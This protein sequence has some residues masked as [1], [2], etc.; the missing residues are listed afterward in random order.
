MSQFAFLQAEFPDI[1]G[2]AARA[3]TL[4]R[5][6]PRGAAFYCRLALETAVGW[7]YR[8][9]GTLKNPYDPTLAALLAEPSFQALVGR[10]LAVKARFVKDTGNAAAHGKPVSSGQAAGSLRE[11]FH[12]AYWL[13]RTYAKGPKPAPDAA[14]SIESLPKITQVAATTLAQLQEVARRF[15]ENVE[16]RQA[17]EEARRL[18]EEGRAA[19]EAEIKALQAEIAAAKAANQKVADTH[20]YREAETRDLFIDLL[21]REA[22]F[23]PKARDAIEVEVAGMPNAPGVGYVDYVLRG[24]DGKP[25]ALVEAKR[26]RKDPRIG[27]QQAKLY[28]D[29]LDKQYGQR[30]I[31]F[32]SNGYDHWIWDDTRHPP[33]P[34][35]GFLKKDELALMIQRRETRK[36][37]APEDIDRAIVERPYQHRAIRRI[38]EAFERD[39]QRKALLVMATGAGKTRTVIALVDLLLRANW[40]KRVLFLADR[41]ALVKQAA[42][43]FAKHLPGAATVNLLENRNQEGR[44]Y[45]STYPTMMGLIDEVGAEERRFGVGH[46][47]LVVIDEAH[48]SVYRKYKAIFEYFDS[49]LVGLTA[50]PKDE[51]DRD[52][53]RLFDL[54]TGVPTDAYGLDEA[55]KDCYLVPPRAVSLTTDFLDRGIRYDDLS[56]DE[57]EAWDALE[58]DDSGAVPAVVDAPA[59]NKWLFNAD[60]VDRVLQHLMA[61]G[62]KVEDGDRIGKT[63]IFAKSHD[64]A[65]FIQSRFDANYPYLAGHH[66][67]VIDFQTTYAQ[68]LIDDFSNPTKAPHI[69]I[70]VDMLDTGIDIP[71]VVNLVFFKPVRSKTKFWQM[72][73]RGT[74]LC[75]DLF[76]PGRHKEFF[77]IFDWCR[78][79]EFFN[80]NPN[81]VDGAGADSLAKRLFAARVEL[82]GEVDGRGSGDAPAGHY[83]QEATPLGHLGEAGSSADRVAEIKSLRNDLVAG[84]RTEISGMSLDNFLVRP[85]RRYVEKYSSGDA[86]KK[87]DADARHE[88]IDHVAGLPSAV[89][90]DDLAAKQFD[91][92]VYRAELAVLRVDPGFQGF[93]KKI[94]EIAS[95]LE[96][97]GNVPMVAAEMALILEVQSDE[98]WQDVT[99]PMLETVRRRLRALVKLIEH[100]KRP[101]VYSDF[102]DVAGAGVDITVPGITVGTDMDAFRRK[103][104]V[105]LRPHENH[106]AVLKLKRNEPLTPMDLKEIERIF[107]DAGVDQA[108]LGTLQADGGLPRFV[109]SL[110]GLDREAAKR[111]FAEFSSGRTLAADQLEFLDLIIDHLTAR[112]VMDPKLLYESPF[113]DFDSKGVEGV[114]EQGDVV[115]LVQILREIEPRSA[116]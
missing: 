57:K 29:C 12:F 11:F 78:N 26:T 116:A 75:P 23:D 14:F 112:G 27:Q 5:V 36:A 67:R 71:E 83:A 33:R 44:V 104:R 17:A 31:I 97:L 53:Y 114:F 107:L 41:T 21:L 100:K 87:L 8:H 32:Y 62:L 2:H 58:W 15:K 76:G 103:A 111:A 34:I 74:R 50:T 65:A 88:L 84:L 38:A 42:R 69:A 99:L 47:D 106:I 30:P 105:F 63:I 10:T 61:Q 55:V 48:R 24:D 60:T 13:A 96:E 9:D 18:S 90:D 73:G 52:T 92:L 39:K 98:F 102:E 37:L 72:I 110:V 49:L 113:T 101:L 40:A 35:Q 66:A 1:F 93:R 45:V 81:R 86:W 91:L 115:R 56:D 89:A 25:L 22:G 51:V 4:A 43:A 80:Q 85:H 54:Q 3:E 82:V 95:L 68:S 94:T 7:L 79:F 16:A 46:F 59:F 28:A 70:S 64:H 109:R 77:Y 6:D 20:D 19:L 108:S